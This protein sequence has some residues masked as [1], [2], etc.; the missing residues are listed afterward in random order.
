[1]RY[2]F[3][4]IDPDHPGRF[5]PEFWCCV[6]CPAGNQSRKIFLCYL[7]ENKT[8]YRQKYDKFPKSVDQDVHLIIN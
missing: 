2:I 8:I 4:D 1:M 6:G 7:P 5:S 3:A